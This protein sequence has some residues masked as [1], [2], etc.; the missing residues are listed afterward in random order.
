MIELLLAPAPLTCTCQDYDFQWPGTD[1]Q[2][3]PNAEEGA[4]FVCEG[5]PSVATGNITLNHTDTCFFLCDDYVVT[6]VS[7]TDG[8]WTSNLKTGLWCYKQ[9]FKCF[10]LD[11]SYMG[12]SI[13]SLQPI[14]SAEACGASCDSRA[15]C[16]YWTYQQT[17]STCFIYKEVVGTGPSSGITCGEKNSVRCAS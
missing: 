11:T 3:N 4:A 13:Q 14:T 9:P 7:C 17:M 16:N 15:D 6:E 5:N 10:L 12:P 8:V 2:Y 1:E